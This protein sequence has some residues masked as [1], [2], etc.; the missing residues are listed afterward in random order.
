MATENGMSLMPAGGE[1]SPMTAMQVAHQVQAIQEVM[2]AVMKPDVHYGTIPGC[3]DKPTLLKPGAEK[4]CLTFGLVPE[5]TIDRRDYD[6]GHREYEVR[7]RLLT[8]SG[9]F[10]GEGV[11][12]CSTLE[13]KYRYRWD[14]TGRMVPKEYWE[15]RN[16][17]LLG[18]DAFVPRKK[19]GKWYIFQ[20]VEHGNPAD[21]HNTC[22][23]I[24]KKRCHVDGTITSTAAGDIFTQDIE[25]LPKEADY[26]ARD[27]KPS[28]TERELAP[29]PV[30]GAKTA[31][32]APPV[33]AEAPTEPEAPT[34]APRPLESHPEEPA[35]QPPDGEGDAPPQSPT[36][37]P[38]WPEWK[39]Q[40]ISE[41]QA[42]RMY[43]I[44]M[45]AGLK[46]DGLKEVIGKWGYGS[47][48]EIVIG[49]YDEICNFIKPGSNKPKEQG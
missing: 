37:P 44:G 43:A 8:R 17:D 21:Y 2:R 14:N 26:S 35:A 1:D 46:K 22:L 36:F 12:V 42:K 27:A 34:A 40:P 25:D 38:D 45:A 48:R 3:G 7:C 20:R 5:F 28:P 49:H 30:N 10:A 13:S 24:A 23:K 4:L 41:P 39:V 32:K 19:D 31:A 47:S 11:G 33:N 15:S 18:G 29:P 16:Q 9:R 6:G